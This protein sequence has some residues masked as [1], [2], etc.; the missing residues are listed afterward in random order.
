MMDS[1]LLSMEEP[2]LQKI[3]ERLG[4][5]PLDF[6]EMWEAI[7]ESNRKG[8]RHGAA[9]VLL[10]LQNR[11]GNRKSGSQPADFILQLIKRSGRVPQ[12]GDISC[13][14]G[15]LHP[16]WDKGLAFLIRN[17]LLPVVTGLPRV[18]ARRRPP[19]AYQLILLFLANAMRESW[20]EIRLNPFNVEFL[21]PLPTYSLF[22]FRRTI[23]PL[24]ALVKRPWMI[25]PNLEVDKAIEIPLAQFFDANNYAWFTIS[26]A[27]TTGATAE[28]RGGFPCFVYRDGDSR[29][30]ILWG[31][32]FKIIMNFIKIVFDFPMPAIQ[33][34]KQYS[35]V[36]SVE[37]TTGQ[38][39]ATKGE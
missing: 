15:M 10:L 5:T 34:D 33:T 6:F 26:S 9:G 24:V 37:Y 16:A 14:G 7:Q 22:S 18:S 3:R 11:Q 12:G 35:R 25:R 2:L 23:F 17:R 19:S 20:E 13:P 4:S 28:E 29:E 38:P 31:A 1:N 30:E 27:Y 21:G 36:L 39:R 32:T 8:M